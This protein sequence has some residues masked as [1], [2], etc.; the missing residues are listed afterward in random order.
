MMRR[1]VL[2]LLGALLLYAGIAIPPA[3]AAEW[4][5][6][7]KFDYLKERGI[8]SGFNDGSAGLDRSMTREQFAQVLYK[9]MELPAPTG[10]ASYWD[11]L[12][13]R[14][15]YEEVEAVTEAGLMAG[16][17]GGKFGPESPVTVEQLAAVLVRANGW[18]TGGQFYVAGR[19]SA[20]AR[21]S[22]AVALQNGLIPQMNDYTG[23][24]KRSLLVEAVYAAYIQMHEEEIRVQSISSIDNRQ[25]RVFLSQPVASADESRF[26]IRDY[27]GAELK[28]WD[29]ILENNGFAVRL[30]TERHAGGQ[31]YTLYADNVPWTYYMLPD[32][33]VKPAIVSFV[34]QLDGK[35]ELTFSEPVDE[36]TARNRANYTLNNGLRVTDVRL[37]DHMQKATLTTTAQKEGTTYRLT[38]KNVKDLAGNAM[39]DWRTD[40]TAD[41]AIPKASFAFNESTGQIMVSFSERVRS[42]YATD[43][44]RYSID[45]GLS[46]IRAELDGDGKTV[47][48]TTS[49]QQDAT[50][51]TLTVSGIPDL[52]GNMMQAQTFRFGGVA[53]PQQ[54]VRL[55]GARPLNQNTIEISFDRALSDTDVSKLGVV[56]LADNGSSFSMAGLESFKMRAPGGDGKAVTVQF[57]ARENNNPALF[58][59]GHVYEIR[60]TG[61]DHL[62]TSGR[63]NETGFAGTETANPAPYVKEAAALGRSAVKIVFSEPVKNVSEAAFIVRKKDG[64]AVKILDDELNNTNAVVTE[65]ALKFAEEL[66]P[67]Q[68]YVMT[69][70]PDTITDAAGWNGLQ[71]KDGSNDFALEFR[72]V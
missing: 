33:T 24:A 42:E 6:Q 56:I 70:R 41:N 32:D 39:N 8:F 2:A 57:R 71:T 5:V 59:P 13:T 12:R 63:A 31:A 64:D 67:G 38:A 14:W 7:Q 21:A 49:A 29:A 15:S 40:F 58:R 9:L 25:L 3:G 69:F 55:Q 4:T 62:V 65:V 51:Y 54:L 53:N 22:V 72:G 66:V 11:V 16:I 34:R 46:V 61:I 60:V 37:S 1:L 36:G 10:K 30:I 26:R 45:K 19:V 43:R 28:V 20:W 23:S 48:L 27:R 47:Y 52:A 44:G 68:I 18:G 35:L 50:V 17:G